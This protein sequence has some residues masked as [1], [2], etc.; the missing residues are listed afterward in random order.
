MAV[1]VGD[2][3]DLYARYRSSRLALVPADRETG[4]KTTILQGW[5][6]GCPV[7]AHAASAATVAERRHALRFGDSPATIVDEVISVFDDQ[8]VRLRLAAAGQAAVAGHA[9][10]AGQLDLFR[11]IVMGGTG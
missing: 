1:L 6:T 5:A 7:V 4:I 8:S 11:S 10:T 3:G 9:D 2:G